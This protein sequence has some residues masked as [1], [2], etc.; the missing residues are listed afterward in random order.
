MLFRSLPVLPYAVVGLAGIYDVKLLVK[1]NEDPG[2]R[3][4]VENAF[5]KNEAVWGLASPADWAYGALWPEGR[6]AVLM[7][8]DGDELVNWSQTNAMAELLEK[9]GTEKRRNVVLKGS[10]AHDDAWLD[11]GDLAR[12][13]LQAL[14]MLQEVDAG[15]V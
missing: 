1:D 3:Q 11:G 9:E 15:K 4:I 13:F 6:V 5:G 12:A 14:S 8:S 2:Y 10:G 7:H